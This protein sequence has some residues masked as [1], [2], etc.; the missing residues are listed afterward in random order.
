MVPVLVTEEDIPPAPSPEALLVAEPAL[1]LLDVDP[2]EML[3]EQAA[4]PPPTIGTRS[5]A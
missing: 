1:P 4:T 3:L 5:M 2:D